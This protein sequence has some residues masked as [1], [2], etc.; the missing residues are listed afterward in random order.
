MRV[1]SNPFSRAGGSFTV[2]HHRRHILS[3]Q[4]FTTLPLNSR[5]I[6]TE[7]RNKSLDLR[8]IIYDRDLAENPIPMSSLYGPGKFVTKE[9]TTL[10]REFLFTNRLGREGKGRKLDCRPVRGK[11]LATCKYDNPKIVP[12]NR[13]FSNFRPMPSC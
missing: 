9:H 4:G 11:W 13:L 1:Q 6:Q 3:H 12:R 10:L 2:L 8:L 7:D 5:R